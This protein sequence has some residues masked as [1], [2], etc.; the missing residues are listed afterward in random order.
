MLPEQQ[1]A[2][3]DAVHLLLDTFCRAHAEGGSPALHKLKQHDFY[4]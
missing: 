1:T 3:G 2:Q 4:L